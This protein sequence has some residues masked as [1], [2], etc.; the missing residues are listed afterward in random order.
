LI[1]VRHHFSGDFRLIRNHR[2]V[3]GAG[4]TIGVPHAKLFIELISVRHH[5]SGDFRPIHNHGHVAGAGVTIER[6]L[7]KLFIA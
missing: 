1:G 7:A 2:H 3:A 4:V 5:F 6:A